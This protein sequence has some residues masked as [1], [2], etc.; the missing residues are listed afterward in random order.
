MLNLISSGSSNIDQRIEI[1]KQATGLIFRIGLFGPVILLW[2]WI[3]SRQ[4]SAIT[5][6][7]IIIGGILLVFLVVWLG[8]I[9]LDRQPTTRR[10]F[11][12]SLFV[13]YT[14][15]TLLGAAIIEAAKTHLAWVGWKIPIP[16]G[17]GYGL[18]IVTSLATLLTVVNL[19]LHG[20]GAPFA[21]ALSQKLAVDWMYAWT[22]NPMVLGTLAFLL[23]LGI[24]F[25]SALFVVWV[26]LLVTPTWLAFIK[27][28]EERELEIRF[29]APYLD[30]KAKTPLLFPR[31]PKA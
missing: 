20:L 30:Y 26:L 25:Q 22:R 21:V 7:Y 18:V 6:L 2:L 28:Y 1:M 15:L 13:H 29:G 17:I 24:W 12:T 27:V 19:A 8:R 16:V 10:A 5:S 9:L 23:A 4:F 11:Q 14:L 3:Q 31:Q